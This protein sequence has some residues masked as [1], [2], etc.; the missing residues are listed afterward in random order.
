MCAPVKGCHISLTHGFGG[1]WAGKTP[2]VSKDKTVGTHSFQFVK[3]W[4]FW[5]FK[6]SLLSICVCE[7]FSCCVVVFIA[8]AVVFFRFAQLLCF[9][10][11]ANLVR[12]PSQILCGQEMMFW[13]VT[14]YI[15]LYKICFSSFKQMLMRSSDKSLL[16]EKSCAVR[17]LISIRRK[18]LSHLPW[19]QLACF[20]PDWFFSKIALNNNVITV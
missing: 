4:R 6:F 5:D 13:Y 15:L 11:R 12:S 17:K 10:F 3:C 1:T 20:N 7:M 18:S 14:I 2:P 19:A 8:K 16:L 9:H